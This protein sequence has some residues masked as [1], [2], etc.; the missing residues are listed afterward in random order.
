MKLKAFI[1]IAFL[2]VASSAF[3]QFFPARATVVVLPGQV[4]VEV[5]NPY[6]EPILC[7]GQVFG[8]TFT[9][10]VFNAFFVQQIIIAGDVRYAL[11]RADLR[12]PF[13]TGWS[14][15]QCRFL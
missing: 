9:G 5:V 13:I 14:N 4:S 7:N 8:Q 10:Q 15:V 11:V 2:T 12:N 1:L 3:A 6:Y